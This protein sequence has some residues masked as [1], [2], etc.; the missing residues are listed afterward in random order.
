MP[1][2]ASTRRFFFLR[3]LFISFCF[4]WLLYFISFDPARR[5]YEP[6]VELRILEVR[7]FHRRFC[8]CT[9]FKYFSSSDDTFRSFLGNL[10]IISLTLLLAVR[11]KFPF[12]IRFCRLSIGVCRTQIIYKF[13]YRWI[14]SWIVSEILI[15]GLKLCRKRLI[16]LGYK[17]FLYFSKNLL[18]S[19][20]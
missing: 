17:F 9:S 13:G 6:F 7:N 8:G 16:I 12:N 11:K 1:N 18:F 19:L 14:A 20:L 2:F 15:R 10:V 5:V 3:S 4:S